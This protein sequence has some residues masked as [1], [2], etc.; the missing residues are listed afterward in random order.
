MRFYKLL[1]V[2]IMLLLAGCQE[3][4]IIFPPGQPSAQEPGLPNNSPT[5]E[6]PAVELVDS[7]PKLSFKQP[8]ELVRPDDDSNRLFVVEK[9]GRI[10][11]F[12]NNPLV[13]SPI[14]FLDISNR[15][16]SG[17]SEKGLL[18]LAFHPAFAQNG[19]F[20]VNYTNRSETIVARYQTS[21]D[22]N[23]TA[24]S[25]SEQILMTIPQPFA[26]HN[27]GRLAFGPDGF[28]YIATGDGGAAGDP[29]GN[30]QNRSSLLGKILRI[31][32]GQASGD[33][34]YGIPHD[35]PFAGN[36]DGYRQEIFA[37]GLRNPWK[38]SFDNI[39]RLWVADVGQNTVEEI[40]VVYKGLNYGW[41][42][43][44]GS[45]CYPAS[46]NCNREGLELPVWEY[47]H[48]LGNSITGGYVYNGKLI[49]QLND[50][51]IYGDYVTGRIWALRLE[52]GQVTTNAELVDSQL[53]ISSF[54]VDQNGELYIVDLGGKIY[55]LQPTS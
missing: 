53:N 48:P 36:K 47:R 40:D 16:D 5:A 45:L 27:G 42:I 26:N 41:N 37:Y 22:S 21:G 12:E 39:G 4:T 35:N 7:F 52:E 23:Q 6:F 11:A 8:V 29:R 54:R 14:L 38:F 34:A 30:A 19:I 43:M 44:E 17:A 3:R 32:V 24:P 15:V 49:P 10:Y 28:L 51:Y 18:G 50:A 33:L 9:Q 13:T 46:N 2:A 55:R 25:D 20:Y 1:I 31:D